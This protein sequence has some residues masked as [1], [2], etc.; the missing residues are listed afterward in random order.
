MNRP[1]V[2]GERGGRLAWVLTHYALDEGVYCFV[3]LHRQNPATG[4]LLRSHALVRDQHTGLT[5][6]MEHTFPAP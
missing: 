4:N 1:E 3:V 6:S 2:S 5:S